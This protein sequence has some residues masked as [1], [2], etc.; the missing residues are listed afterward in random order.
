MYQNVSK[1]S[2][3]PTFF[4]FGQ[5]DNS[6]N[7]VKYNRV[8]KCGWFSRWDDDIRTS[9]FKVTIGLN[10]KSLY[11]CSCQVVKETFSFYINKSASTSTL[12]STGCITKI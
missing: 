12:L 9:T 1:I 6:I 7:H 10:G 11:L 2:S 3:F 4:I 8:G 5:I